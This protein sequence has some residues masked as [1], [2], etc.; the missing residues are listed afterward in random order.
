MADALEVANDLNELALSEREHLDYLHHYYNGT[1]DFR[2]FP[3]NA[4]IPGEMRR[5]ADMARVNIMRLVVGSL[6]QSL[7]VDGYRAATSAENAQAWEAWQANRLDRRQIGLHRSTFVYGVGYAVVLPGDLAPVVSLRSPRRLTTMYGEDMYAPLFALEDLRNGLVRLLDDTHAYYFEADDLKLTP[8]ESQ[9]HGIG[10]CPV[11]RFVNVD[12]VDDDIYSEVEDLIPLQDQIDATT[13]DLLV[14]Q[15]FGA[16]RQRYILGWTAQEE[17]DLL[18]ASAQR[19]WTFEDDPDDI[20]IGEFG[21]TDLKGFLDSREHTLRHVATVSQ[22]PV[23][24]LLGT[25]VNLSAEALVA[26]RD[27]QDRKLEEKATTLGESWEQ[28]LGLIGDIENYE[29]PVD[30]Q[31]RWRDSKSRSLSATA[32]ALGKLAAQLGVPKREL[33]AKIPGVTDTDIARWKEAADEEDSMSTLMGFL[34]QSPPE[35]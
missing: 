32:D 30:A 4:G 8:I 10:R 24:E 28:V 33:W 34:D 2:A 12:D 6:A 27:S 17:A 16:F 21:Q 22:T 15:H 23:H 1:H 26:A 3:H 7:F 29:T 25:L 9:E 20:K 5:M 14:A 11:I 31:V 35:Q 19:I 13:F 18:K